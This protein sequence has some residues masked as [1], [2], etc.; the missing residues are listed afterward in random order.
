G[1]LSSTAI[2]SASPIPEP[3]TYDAHGNMTSMPHLTLMRWDYKDE[4]IVTSRQAVNDMTITQYSAGD[5]F[6]C[7]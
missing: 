1:Q 5:D 6:L 7:L 3:Y 2:V 4:L